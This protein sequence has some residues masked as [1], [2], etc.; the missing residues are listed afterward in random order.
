MKQKTRLERHAPA[1]LLISAVLIASLLLG[2]LY[3]GP[4]NPDALPKTHLRITEVMADNRTTLADDNGDFYSWAEITNTGDLPVDLSALSLT[5][6]PER[7][8]RYVFPDSILKSGER[9]LV[10]LS[11]KNGED[12]P[13][14]ASFGLKKKGDTLYLFDGEQLLHSLTIS[15]NGIDRSFGLKDGEAGWFATSTPKKENVGIHAPTL[16]A[17]S[18]AVYTGVTIN[19]VGA[20]SRNGD[21]TYPHDFVELLN[22]TD[23]TVDLSGYRLTED[24]AE[25]G[26]LLEGVSL[27]QQEYLLISAQDILAVVEK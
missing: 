1:V 21:S 15:E 7:P 2:S 4:A 5:D 17:L 8:D 23:H 10:Y 24:L 27:A 13:W 25:Q 12:R 16:E 9:V 11:G 14:Y 26:L 3:L 22:T 19:E 6:D 20:V 18:Q